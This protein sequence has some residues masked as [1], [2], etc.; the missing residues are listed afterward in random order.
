[1][2]SPHQIVKIVA[3]LIEQNR[4]CYVNKY[5]RE[6]KDFDLSEVNLPEVKEKIDKIEEKIEKY[7]KIGPMPKQNL[8]YV[9]EGFLTEVMDRG[10]GKELEK[11]LKRKNPTRNFLQIAESREDINQ[12]WL[13]Y[14]DEQ[15]IEYVGEIFVKEYNY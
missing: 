13:V 5:S 3:E 11:S 1:M 14:F 4:I 15:Q 12:H 7:I 6:V 10:I 8:I 9:M 2:N